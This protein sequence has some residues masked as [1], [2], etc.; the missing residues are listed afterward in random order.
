[1]ALARKKR[2]E[3]VKIQLKKNDQVRVISGKDKGKSGRVLDVDESRGRVLVEHVAMIKRHTRPNPAKQIKGGI[4]ERE[5]SIAVSNVMILCPKCGP[6]R[7]AHHV[8]Q[9][10]GGKARRTRVC[11]KC[12]QGL[13]SK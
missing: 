12:G 2:M 5:S 11:R 7:I 8:D 10:A 6:V 3:P 1:M 9:V 4:A 13:E